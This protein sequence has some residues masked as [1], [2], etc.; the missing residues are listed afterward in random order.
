MAEAPGPRSARELL[1]YLRDHAP[2]VAFFNALQLLERLLPGAARIGHDGPAD[3]ERLRLRPSLALSCPVADLESIEL[4]ANERD[5]V[6]LTVTFLGLYGVDSPLPPL[7][8]EHLAQNADE[9]GSQRVRAFLDLFHHRLYSLLFRAWRK[10]HPVGA[11]ERPDALYDRLLALTGYASRL[12]L[13]GPT[14]PRLAEARIKVLQARTASG[15]EAMLQLRTGHRCRVEQAVA[16][17]ASI[18]P[19]QRT[20]LGRQHCELGNNLVAGARAIDRNLVFLHVQAEDHAAWCRLAPRGPDRRALELAVGDYLREPVHYELV[21]ELASAQAPP[22]RLGT[23][24]TAL[25]RDTWLG[26]PRPVARWRWRRPPT[27]NEATV[28]EVAATRLG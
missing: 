8:G 28:N 23:R 21:T 24:Q 19:D 2:Q 14:M 17:H 26:R 25:G 18:P 7:Y 12:G 16:R 5:P 15:L 3:D 9:P 27:A 6:R 20:Q 13:G 1:S 11:G 10:S 22:W 4:P